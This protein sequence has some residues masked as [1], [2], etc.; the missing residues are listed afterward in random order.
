MTKMNLQIKNKILVFSFIPIFFLFLDFLT[1]N[2]VQAQS[3]GIPWQGVDGLRRGLP[4]AVQTGTIKKDRTVGIFYFLWNS[5][6]SNIQ[7]A[8]YRDGPYDI[9]DIFER[10]PDIMTKP[11]S[12]LW[13]AD[14]MFHFWGEPLFGYYR[15]DDPWIMRRHINLLS[16]AGIDVLIFDTTNALTYPE[17]YLPLCETMKTIRMEGGRTPQIAFML[18]T[19]ASA[20]AEKLWH[21]IYG[22]GKYNELL[23]QW[24]GKPLLIGDP[25]KITNATIKSNLTLR[26][27][28]WPFTMVNTKNSWHWEATY[29][30][31]YSWSES[32][33]KPEQVNVSVAQN[34][35]RA[36]GKVANMSSGEARGRSFC[37][38]QIVMKKL[39][40]DEGRNFAEQWSRA[41]ELDPPFVMITGWNE[42][43]AGRWPQGKEYAFVDQFDREYSRD[44]EPM[45]GKH[46][47]NYY[48]QMIAGIRRYKGTEVPPTIPNQKTIVIN[49]DF[50]QWNEVQPTFIDH[51]GETIPR[52][53]PGV[54]GTHYTN[55]T[56]RNDLIDMKVTYDDKNVYFLIRA[57]ETIR[58]ELPDGLCLLLNVDG[59]YRTG[60]IGGDWLIGR[61]YQK[62]TVSL[63]K[64]NSDGKRDSWSWKEQGNVSWFMQGKELHLAIPFK[65][66]G[67]S[68]SVDSMNR[69]SFKW[70]DNVAEAMTVSDL[71]MTGDVA[72][73]GRF[74]YSFS[75]KKTEK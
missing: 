38:N 74:F 39:A 64:Y 8:P 3:S 15:A 34:L 57:K 31:P 43:I 33:D 27:A 66:L 4:G 12:P 59:N 62:G 53:F 40:T 52:D 48:M 20:T 68:A 22:T 10:D 7:K 45:K 58:P 37:K 61:K 46:F 55:K 69:L 25:D 47:D 19:N 60:W 26:K 21:E 17:I 51:Q 14:G 70:M 11:K 18:N 28:H 72:P 71:Y 49:S 32:P 5:P 73:E 44:I 56:G 42:W 6:V 30:Q 41:L 35:S 23:F 67:I 13:A 29:P 1:D 16:D 9:S 63:E 75:R 50:R 24:E 2:R 54:G 36:T 65:S